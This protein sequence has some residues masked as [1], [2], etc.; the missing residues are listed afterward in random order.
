MSE[1]RP[2]SQSSILDPQSSILNPQS[3]FRNPPSAFIQAGGRS[4]RMGTDKAWFE[5][6]GRPMIEWVLAAA[7]PIAK[8]LSI[9]I[10]PANRRADDYRSLCQ[11]WNAQLLFDLHDHQGPLGGVHTALKNCPPERSALILACDLP[12]V[13]T[14]FLSLLSEIHQNESSE[15]TLPVDQQGRLQGVAGFYA[16]A[17]LPAVERLLDEKI[18][19][20]DRLCPLVKTRRIEYKEFSHLHRAEMLLQN[21]N[22]PDEYRLSNNK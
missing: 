14:E 20:L 4:S 7:Q 12:F 8:D 17:C 3:G 6:E 9:I 21:I 22:T 11:R 19:R 13:T 5:I 1:T 16:P 2:K 15:L 10:N 18:L